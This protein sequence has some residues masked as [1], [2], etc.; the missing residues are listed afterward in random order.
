M[1]FRRFAGLYGSALHTLISNRDVKDLK[2]LMNCTF[3]T[4][5]AA[6]AT[7]QAPHV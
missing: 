3:F 6:L 1:I 5:P 4:V 2:S 7:F